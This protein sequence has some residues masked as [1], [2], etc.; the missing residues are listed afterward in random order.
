MCHQSKR[1]NGKTML[2]LQILLQLGKKMLVIVI[3]K[4]LQKTQDAIRLSI[5]VCL[6]NS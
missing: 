4:T 5:S 3:L 1:V 6:P 2:P